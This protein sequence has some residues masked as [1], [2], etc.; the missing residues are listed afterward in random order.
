MGRPK[1]VIGSKGIIA[2]EVFQQFVFREFIKNKSWGAVE[3][4]A[5]THGIYNV[6]ELHELIRKHSPIKNVGEINMHI[7]LVIHEAMQ[8]DKKLSFHAICVNNMDKLCVLIGVDPNSV[9]RGEAWFKN[10]KSKNKDL[11]R[12]Q[13]SKSYIQII[14]AIDLRYKRVM[15]NPKLFLTWYKQNKGDK[16]FSRFLFWM[17]EKLKSQ[18]KILK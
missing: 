18:N 10:Q 14:N 1:F 15:R 3:T 6:D 5:K 16:N 13:F 11:K 7:C 9:S 4:I 2:T 8:K 12:S 17:I